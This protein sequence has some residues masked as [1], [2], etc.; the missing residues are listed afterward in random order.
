M[1]TLIALMVR[2]RPDFDAPPPDD[3]PAL[4]ERAEALLSELHDSMK[5]PWFDA[6]RK[7]M[8]GDESSNPWTSGD[9][10]REPIFYSGDGAFSV[11]IR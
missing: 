1:F 4:A 3:M 5:R 2:A 11:R 8:A 7:T 9:A 10:M 6:I